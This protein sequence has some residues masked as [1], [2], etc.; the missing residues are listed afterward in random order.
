MKILSII[1]IVWGF[2]GI[3]KAFFMRKKADLY[4]KSLN[5]AGIEQLKMESGDKRVWKWIEKHGYA[6]TFL[7]DYAVSVEFYRKVIGYLEQQQIMSETEF[8]NCCLESTPE[9]HIKYTGPLL[10]FLQ[11]KELLFP[12]FSSTGEIFYVSAEVIQEYENLFEKE[13]DE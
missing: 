13:Q 1:L 4:L 11:Q 2:A 8:Q 12:F 5:R 6:E 3:G 10:G 7:S 9:F